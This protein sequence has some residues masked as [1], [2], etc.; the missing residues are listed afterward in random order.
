[1][2]QVVPWAWSCKSFRTYHQRVAYFFDK[3]SYVTSMSTSESL[4]PTIPPPQQELIIGADRPI[5]DA[6]L[7]NIHDL[8]GRRVPGASRFQELFPWAP[9]GQPRAQEISSLRA[10]SGVRV[11]GPSPPIRFSATRFFDARRTRTIQG[12]QPTNN[13]PRLDILLNHSSFLKYQRLHQTEAKLLASLTQARD[14][15]CATLTKIAAVP[16]DTGDFVGGMPQWGAITDFAAEL[17]DAIKLVDE[18]VNVASQTMLFETRQISEEVAV[19]SGDLDL[20]NQLNPGNPFDIKRLKA[21]QDM[22]KRVERQ[23]RLNESMD[24]Y[25]QSGAR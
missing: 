25:G 23:A 3:A 1:M 11:Q 8:I 16:E 21:L 20:H 15:L 18:A 12:S 17:D 2:I 10:T 7:H 4:E 24:G 13:T 9:L 5:S 14:Q 19:L 6:G 22:S